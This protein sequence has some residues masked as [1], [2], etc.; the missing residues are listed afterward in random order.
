M[1]V[2][3]NY[4]VGACAP[5]GLKLRTREAQG[6]L[7]GQRGEAGAQRAQRLDLPPLLRCAHRKLAAHLRRQE[8]LLS[9]SVDMRQLQQSIIDQPLAAATPMQS[10][11]LTQATGMHGT[12]RA[13]AINMPHSN[14]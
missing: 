6:V 13:E 12:A 9:P 8:A 10:A 5:A 11:R 1:A 3:C 14:H 7:G 2:S 4:P